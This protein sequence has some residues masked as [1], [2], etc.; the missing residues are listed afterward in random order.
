MY[1]VKLQDTKLIHRNLAY[2]Y[3]HNKR[4]EQKIN[5]W[6]RIEGPEINSHAYGHLIY[7]QR[8]KNIH[9]RKDSLFSK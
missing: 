6:N 1:L 2:L 3:T 5:Q 9:W 8:G 4:S 7:D